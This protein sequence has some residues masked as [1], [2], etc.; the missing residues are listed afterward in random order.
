MRQLYLAKK[1]RGRI[2][3]KFCDPADAP[4]VGRATAHVDR[5]S[6]KGGV[7][8]PRLLRH[9]E[10]RPKGPRDLA[11]HAEYDKGASV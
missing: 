1:A 3:D 2:G 6:H 5:L 8:Q 4:A 10:V 7:K 11:L 9:P